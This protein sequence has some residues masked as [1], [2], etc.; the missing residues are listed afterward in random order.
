MRRVTHRVQAAA[1]QAD[2]QL[3]ERGMARRVVGKTRVEV[4]EKHRARG[5]EVRVAEMPRLDARGLRRQRQTARHHDAVRRG[6]EWM[7][8]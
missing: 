4:G 2:E 8:G 5:V 7:R 1:R 6:R 3:R